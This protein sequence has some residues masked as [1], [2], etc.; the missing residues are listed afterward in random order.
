MESLDNS[1]ANKRIISSLLQQKKWCM[2]KR[3]EIVLLKC[4]KLWASFRGWKSYYFS[5]F[6][7]KSEI[8]RYVTKMSLVKIVT[9]E[10]EA[11]MIM[12][13][14][15]WVPKDKWMGCFPTIVRKLTPSITSSLFPFF[16][17][18]VKHRLFSLTLKSRGPRGKTFEQQ[19]SR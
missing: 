7:R 18:F 5:C 3:N 9:I 14:C 4:Q 11:I 1:L 12:T 8:T 19:W 10:F 2:K 13:P 6:L 16:N 17:C 15:P